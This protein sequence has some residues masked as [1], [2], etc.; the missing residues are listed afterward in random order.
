MREWTCQRFEASTKRTG[1]ELPATKSSQH[2]TLSDFP[3]RFY[4]FTRQSGTV[5]STNSD[6]TQASAAPPIS[7]ASSLQR[8]EKKRHRNEG[9]RQRFQ[10]IQHQVAAS[11]GLSLVEENT[12]SSLVV[13]PRRETAAV[14]TLLK[15]KKELL[16]ETLDENPSRWRVEK[17]ASQLYYFCKRLS[18]RKTA[19]S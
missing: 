17:N 7:I 15:T 1:K 6:N 5:V 3:Y 19:T 2:F 8:V 11:V 4:G 9:R 18:S 12:S 16:R 10:E 13:L 14:E